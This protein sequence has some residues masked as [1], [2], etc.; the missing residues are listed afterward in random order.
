[1][2]LQ[3]ATHDI[4]RHFVTGLLHTNEDHIQVFVFVP[5]ILGI[6]IRN[7]IVTVM[8]KFL[9]SRF[10]HII[11]EKL[12]RGTIFIFTTSKFHKW[13]NIGFLYLELKVD[14]MIQKG[15]GEYILDYVSVCV[16]II[17]R[18]WKISPIRVFSLL[19]LKHTFKTPSSF[20]T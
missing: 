7:Q 18:K 5:C 4:T 2:F 3:G 10:A 6:T 20:Y 17:F 13:R 9:F 16:I 11:I 8:H 1:V 12:K 19:F 14:D 15:R